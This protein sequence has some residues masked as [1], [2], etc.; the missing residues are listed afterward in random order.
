MVIRGEGTVTINEVGLA[1]GG[2]L[3][4]FD[5]KSVDSVVVPGVSV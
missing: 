4:V 2:V 1:R 3:A 5:R